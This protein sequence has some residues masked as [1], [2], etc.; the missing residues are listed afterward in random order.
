MTTGQFGVAGQYFKQ[1]LTV[2]Q[3][4]GD[5]WGTIWRLSYLGLLS[6]QQDDNQTALT[7][8]AEAL[9]IAREF[10]AR[11]EQAMVLTHHAHALAG[12]GQWEQA[13]AA[14][15]QALVLRKQ[16]GESS[17]ELETLAGL[18]RLSL[19]R[20]D[21]AQALADIEHILAALSEPGAL[22]GADEPGRIYLTCWKVLQ[23]A[24]DPRAT[25][26]KAT[27]QAWLAECARQI[28]DPAIQHSF[29]HNI[30]AHRALQ[31]L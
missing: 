9:R 12:S 6:H 7:L 10:G 14:Y 16:L 2:C 15:E 26:V 13:Q 30:P 27:G 21:T 17:L 11:H 18:A 29:L 8:T 19:V 3:A 25:Q 1:A 31:E 28:N 23:A 22:D 5:R 4:A 24:G 20:S